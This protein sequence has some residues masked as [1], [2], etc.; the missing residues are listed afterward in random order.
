MSTNSVESGPVA[1][2]EQ[3]EQRLER[4]NERVAE[5]GEERLQRLADVYHEFV[6]MSPPSS[7]TWSS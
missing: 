5:F 1:E 7:V 3:C 4:A 6:W 2:L